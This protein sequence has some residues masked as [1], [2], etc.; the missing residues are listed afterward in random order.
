M[1]HT[2]PLQH[3]FLFWPARKDAFGGPYLKRAGCLH[4]GPVREV[5]LLRAASPPGMRG[6]GVLYPTLPSH[7]V[8]RCVLCWPA[9]E[10]ALVGPALSALDAD[11]AFTQAQP[12][13]KAR[14]PRAAAQ[15]HAAAQEARSMLGGRPC[16]GSL[17]PGRRGLR[18][19]SA[20][21][22]TCC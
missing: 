2:C 11:I 17:L 12:T 20:C 13:M 6:D 19:S 4:R 10:Y 7:P 14:D 5:N 3:C 21:S 1:P 9:G 8:H 22:Q 16:Y 15:M 18:R